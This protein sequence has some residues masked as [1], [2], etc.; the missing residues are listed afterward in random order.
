MRLGLLIPKR[1]VHAIHLIGLL[2]IINKIESV[3]FI[4]ILFSAMAQN[5]YACGLAICSVAL[6]MRRGRGVE[7][8]WLI[9]VLSN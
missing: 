7:G 6:S 5:K 2:K 4:F 1:C 3:C 9:P 8:G